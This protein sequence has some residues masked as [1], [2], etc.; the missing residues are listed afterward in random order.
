MNKGDLIR[1]IKKEI[2][3]S[4]QM[5][6]GIKHNMPKMSEIDLR[7]IL[8]EMTDIRIDIEGLI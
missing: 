4:K 8:D 2:K 1:E 3:S 7:T 6:D 5:L